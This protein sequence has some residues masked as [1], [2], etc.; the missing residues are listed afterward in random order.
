[1]TNYSLGPFYRVFIFLVTGI[2]GLGILAVMFHLVTTD[3]AFYVR[4]FLVFWIVVAALSIYW[5]L[6]RIAYD[7]RFDTERLYWMSP[8]RSGSF[9]LQELQRI[10]VRYGTDAI[11]ESSHGSRV[12]VLA[13]KG[14]AKFCRR[15][16]A[17]QPSLDLRI[18]LMH[19]I[20]EWLPASTMF[21]G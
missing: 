12:H 3:E 2:F 7:L 16:A 20:L 9:S 4:G 1:V 15:L 21:R 19:R 5:Y 6:F 14:F 10:R 18:G 11:V 8:L 17:Q 13:Q